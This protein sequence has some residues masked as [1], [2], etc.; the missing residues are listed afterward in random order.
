MVV[1]IVDQ[2]DDRAET[3]MFLVSGGGADAPKRDDLDA[4]LAR[5]RPVVALEYSRD[6]SLFARTLDD[7]LELGLGIDPEPVGDQLEVAAHVPAGFEFGDMVADAC[8]DFVGVRQVFPV[9]VPEQKAQ[10]VRAVTHS[11][12]S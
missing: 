3:V 12:R 9:Q 6:G 11:L 5:M 7:E 2:A 10:H 1:Q 4:V 8:A